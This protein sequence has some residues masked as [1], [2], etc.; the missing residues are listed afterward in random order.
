MYIDKQRSWFMHCR[1][2]EQRC[3]GGIQV[4]STVGV[5]LDL[6]KH[7]LSFFVND[8]PQV[9]INEFKFYLIIHSLRACTIL[10]LDS[11]QQLSVS[12]FVFIQGPVAFNGLYGVF[13][14]AVSVNRGVAVTLH[15]A[16]DAPTDLEDCQNFP[17]ISIRLKH[18]YIIIYYGCNI[19][20]VSSIYEVFFFNHKIIFYLKFLSKLY[21]SNI[22]YLYACV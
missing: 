6:N 20:Q 3:E 19:M 9:R 1:S 18:T 22:L 7:Q 5:L 14:P 10:K 2:H 4:G 15:T 17:I 13:Y 16:L 8:E 11:L 12:F 21:E